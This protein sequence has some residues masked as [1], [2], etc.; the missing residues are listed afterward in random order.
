[1]AI[2]HKCLEVTFGSVKIAYQGHGNM[3]KLEPEIRTG[4]II[5]SRDK[6]MLTC[7]F[8]IVLNKHNTSC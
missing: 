7:G 2:S 5:Q 6:H 8:D 4:Q 3:G 1:M